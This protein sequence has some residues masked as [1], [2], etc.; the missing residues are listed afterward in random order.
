MIQRVNFQMNLSS[1]NDAFVED[2]AGEMIRLLDDVKARIERGDVNGI[3][4]DRNGNRVG[5]WDLDIDDG[6]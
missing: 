1:G 5:L 4:W 3:L 6:S 2:P